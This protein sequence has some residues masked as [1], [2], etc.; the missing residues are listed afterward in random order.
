MARLMAALHQ[1]DRPLTVLAATSGDT[2]SAVAHAFHRVPHTRVVV[3]Y[4]DGRVSPTQE[5]QLTIFNGQRT[6]VRAFAVAGS[7]DDCHRLTREAFRDPELRRRMCLTSANSVNVGRLLPQTVY[8]FHAIALW[9]A[10][11][12]PGGRATATPIV[13]ATPSGNIGTLTAGLMAKRAGLAIDRFIAATNVNDVVPAY[14]ESGRFEPRASVA[15]IANA[16]DVGDPSNFARML[17]LYGGDLEAMRRDVLGVRYTD[18]QVRATIRE[19]YR[20]TGYVLD[21]HSAIGYLGITRARGK[22][23]QKSS[24]HGIFLATA[25]PAKFAEVVEPIIGA[26][27]D[28]PAALAEAIASPRHIVKIAATLGALKAVL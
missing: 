3:L 17:W 22:A 2:G 18:D 20:E 9:R 28:K 7:F 21:P 25:H 11:H 10:I 19:V 16:M 23:G 4:P 6:N 15:T 8:Y 5:A 12:E 1:D 26:P 14:L 24:G 13:V 27:V